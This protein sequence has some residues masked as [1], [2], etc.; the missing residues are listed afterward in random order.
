[1]K[2]ERMKMRA[3]YWIERNDAEVSKDASDFVVGGICCLATGWV[4][5]DDF[6]FLHT[7]VS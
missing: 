7:A 5:N 1:M 3:K 2:S 6:G 4:S